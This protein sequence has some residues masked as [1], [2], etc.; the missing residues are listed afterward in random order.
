MPLT[1]VKRK[2]MPIKL[3]SVVSADTLNYL[4]SLSRV[5]DKMSSLLFLIAIRQYE[6]KHNDEIEFVSILDK[7]TLIFKNKQ[8]AD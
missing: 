8:H 1:P 3:S 6:K 2:Y 7:H 5:R 4:N